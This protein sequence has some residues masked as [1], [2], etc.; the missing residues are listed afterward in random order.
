[1]LVVFTLL[2]DGNSLHFR[3]NKYVTASSFFFLSM[4]LCDDLSLSFCR[5][6]N[7]GN[8]NQTDLKDE[9]DKV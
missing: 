4:Y 3:E 5:T 6:E 2:T 7:E 9:K 1:M 8:E